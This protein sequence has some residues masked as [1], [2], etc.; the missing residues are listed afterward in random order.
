MG[1]VSQLTKTL[2]P[3]PTDL[4]RTRCH[5]W[6]FDDHAPTVSETQHQLTAMGPLT[7]MLFIFFFNTSC[8]LFVEWIYSYCPGDVF[9]PAGQCLAKQ[10]VKRSCKSNTF[11]QVT[12]QVAILKHHLFQQWQLNSVQCSM[13]ACF[14]AEFCTVSLVSKIAHLWFHVSSCYEERYHVYGDG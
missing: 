12:Y 10:A 14:P 4:T 8:N 9:D 5:H 3:S 6:T 13:S 1:F 11:I 7:Q 2:Q